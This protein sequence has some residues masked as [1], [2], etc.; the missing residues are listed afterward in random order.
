MIINMTTFAGRT[1]HY[2][3]KALE[4]LLRSDGRH[5]PVNL[6]VGS[7][8]TSHV[9]Q[10]RDVANIVL[11]GP[12][13]E[14]Q[15]QPGKRRFNCNINA[16]RALDYGEDDHCLC[17][18]DDIEFKEHWF[19]ELMLTIEQIG[20]RDYVLNLGQG[21]DQSPDRRYV[22]HTRPSLIGAQGIFYP[23]KPLRRAVADYLRQNIHKSTNDHLIGRYA[24]EHAVLYNTCPVL[25][26][27]I[28]QVSSFQAEGATSQSSERSR[29]AA[30]ERVVE[31]AKK[32]AVEPQALQ[33]HVVRKDSRTTSELLVSLLRASL[34]V[35]EPP[36]PNRLAGCDWRHFERIAMHHGL[37]GIVYRGLR[38]YGE[39][40]PSWPLRTF[41]FQY[42]ANAFRSREAA[43]CVEQVGAA[44]ETEGLRLVVMK[45]AALLR[46]LY[47]DP[48]LRIIGDVDLLVGERHVQQAD[49]LLKRIGFQ[50]APSHAEGRGPLCHIHRVYCRPES[51]ALPIELHWRLFEPYQPYVFDLDAVWSQA[52]NVSG[53]PANVSVMSPGHELAHLC[54]HLDRHAVTFRSLVE[55]KD[56]LELLT[57]PQ[58]LGRLVWLYDIALCLQRHG[59]LI[60]WDA[61]VDAARRWAMDERLYATLELSRRAL[62]VGPPAE[63][64]RAL[65]RTQPRF[66]ERLAHRVVFASQRANELAKSGSAPSE[67]SDRLNRL[68]AHVQRFANAWVSTFP[69][70]ACLRARYAPGDAPLRLWGRHFRDVVPGL[71]A[72]TRD[73]IKAA[74]A[75]AGRPPR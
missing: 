62:G 61:F 11:W 42:V 34:G 54:V 67:R 73:R 53:A 29:R 30:Q 6:I 27:H 52:R 38:S 37:G 8:D 3:G 58:G 24:K 51:R 74:A 60:D 57:I 26:R 70:N 65:H 28:G 45:G 46:T 33:S 1:K 71:W 56:W 19:S 69:P 5:I 17:C 35:E 64:L 18:E 7:S 36:D 50:A 39:R 68:S 4:S 59:G 13:A 31:A 25:I 47:D 66:V 12:E 9:E 22:V 75:R 2:V 72:E 23:N 21:C 16:I 63:V 43:E 40:V 49:A 20:V 44:F 55:R 41:K 32:R 48:G 10:F 15:A 14:L